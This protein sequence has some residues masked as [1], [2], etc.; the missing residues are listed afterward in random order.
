MTTMAYDS[1]SDRVVLFG[2]SIFVRGSTLHTDETWVYDFNTNSWTFMNPT[3]RPSPRSEHAMAYDAQSDRIIMFGGF[4]GMPT[5]FAD[6]WAY[7]FNTNTWTDLTSGM[8]PSGRV[9]P[10][11]AYDDESD[12]VVLFGGST[13]A[14]SDETW[15]YDFETNTWTD[16]T[17]TARP[18]GRSGH[19][20]AYD[21]Q[22]DRVVLF[23]GLGQFGPRNDTWAYDFNTNVWTNLDPA[24]HPSARVSHSMTYD[25][26][27]DRVILFGGDPG[28]LN[29]ETWTYDLDANV[30]E[31]ASPATGPAARSGH[32]LLY[33][34][35]SDRIVLF[36]GLTFIGGFVDLPSDTWAY[37]TD[38]NEWTNANPQEPGPP[39]RWRHAIAYDAESDRV[40]LFG[41]DTGVPDGETWSYDLD[42]NAWS[43][44]DPVTSPSPR[45]GHV[46]SY[47]SQS[48]RIILFGGETTPYVYE[49]SNETWAY[50]FNT[51]EW[52]NATPPIGP[53]ARRDPAM[54]YDSES[55][56]V[57]LFGGYTPSE[58]LDDTWTYDV[59]TNTWT[60]MAPQQ[61]PS[62]RSGHAVAYDA[63]SDRVILFGGTSGFSPLNETWAYDLNANEWTGMQPSFVWPPARFNHAMAYDAELDR[64]VLFGGETD[65]RYE[66][67]ETWLY[68]FDL[69][70]WTNATPTT[71]PSARFWHAMA[72]DTQSA[73]VILFGGSSGD[74]ET[75]SYPGITLPGTPAGGVPWFVTALA[76]VAAIGF[77][78]IVA[79]LLIRRRWKGRTGTKESD[80][81]GK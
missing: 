16:V 37:D 32:A 29:D 71:G 27:S 14:E 79:A 55:D 23:G 60:E 72:Y 81:H 43:D 40:I 53:S 39:G 20:M 66:D 48:D 2:G 58:N 74:D 77:T 46:M 67:G 11:M 52:R 65:S 18:F 73:R 24:T 30:W 78:V 9:H 21:A 33:D 41:G 31:N 12:R 57:V 70:M 50:D 59:D 22:S 45:W 47:D 15:A 35:Q 17:P 62:A 38:T 7:D 36:G 42:R 63:E 76:A 6:T 69:D 44:M 5:V 4:V 61:R 75:W 3:T 54:A 28:V 80:D 64:V 56:R 13:G 26:E 8:A 10:A 1:E 68:D 19:A 51:N 25:T 34:A 49:Y